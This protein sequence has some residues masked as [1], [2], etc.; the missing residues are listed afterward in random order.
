MRSF[1]IAAAVA[2][3][4]TLASGRSADAQVMLNLGGNGM[5]AGV[6]VGQPYYGGG[7]A[8]GRPYGA[9][10]TP[11]YS[12]TTTTYGSGYRG[13]FG[14]RRTVTTTQTYYSPYGYAPGYGYATG[15]GVYLNAPFLGPLRVR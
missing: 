9:P 12:T 14:P 10:Y 6:T 8:Y 1:I 3:G 15:R 11:G 2:A 4:L 5:P 13:L 7:Y